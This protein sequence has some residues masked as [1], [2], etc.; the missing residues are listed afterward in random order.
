[1]DVTVII[2]NYN[3]IQYIEGCLCSLYAGTM[4]PKIILVDNGSADGSRE[5][6]QEKFKTVRVIAFSEN[7]GFCRAVN[8]GVRAADTEYV[9][10]LNNDTAVEKHFVERLTRAVYH[11]HNVFSAG[12]KLLSMRE[13]DL[14]DDAG[15]LYC[16]LGWAFALGKGQRKENYSKRA[17]IFAACAGA[18][19]YQK[20]VLERLGGFDENHFAY[21]EDIDIGYRAKLAGYENLFVPEAVVYHAGSSVSGSRHNAFKVR[22]SSRNS[23]YLIYKNMPFLQIL[24]NAPFL[25]AGFLIKGIFFWK[26]GLG[27]TYLKGLSEGAALCLS[28]KGKRKRVPFQTVGFG[29]YCR[30]QAELWINLLR[31]A[32][33]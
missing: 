30:I 16:A 14:I 3:G 12:A 20:S 9:I 1:M 32:L 25:L 27:G 29:S 24:L 5:L 22:L 4:I 33:G 15:D 31:R 2:P 26:K 28:E 13:P 6:V 10:L 19:I 18:A 21:L 23:V 8:A 11:K 7:T 17:G